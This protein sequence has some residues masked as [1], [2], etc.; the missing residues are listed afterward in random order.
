MSTTL[1]AYIC[2]AIVAGV[3]E[4]KDKESDGTHVHLI[5][6][7]GVVSPECSDGKPTLRIEHAPVYISYNGSES[8][9]EEG[10]SVLLYVEAS[11]ESMKGVDEKL[12]ERF[13]RWVSYRA[14]KCDATKIIPVEETK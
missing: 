5:K 8:L 6:A 3:L 2:G 13:N 14:W 10:S 12:S 4:V 7:G 11:C 9:G 1:T